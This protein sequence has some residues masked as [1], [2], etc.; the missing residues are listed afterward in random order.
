VFLLL[1]QVKKRKREYEY[2][3]GSES[4]D[5]PAAPGDNNGQY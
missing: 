5:E 4:G 1:G 3:S 2:E